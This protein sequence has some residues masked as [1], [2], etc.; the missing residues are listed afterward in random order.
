MW[1]ERYWGK[2]SN[3]RSHCY[4]WIGPKPGITYVIGINLTKI[5]RTEI[6]RFKDAQEKTLE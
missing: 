1:S 5:E 2:S 3:Y 4:Y 6:G